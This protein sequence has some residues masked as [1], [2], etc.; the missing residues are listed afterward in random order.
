MSFQKLS[1]FTPIDRRLACFGRVLGHPARI[2]ILRI[3]AARGPIP[4][5]DLKES[6]PM[7]AMTLSRHLQYLVR[8]RCILGIP[9][10]AKSWFG[11]DDTR[12][13]RDLAIMKRFLRGVKGGGRE[14]R[15]KK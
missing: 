2:E 10:G 13:G 15:G 7:H 14:A 5:A 11:V 4:Y 9:D 6:I 1:P 12:L 3:L 8:H